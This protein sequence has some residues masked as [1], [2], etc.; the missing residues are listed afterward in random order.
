MPRQEARYDSLVD[1]VLLAQ[2]D[3]SEKM[4]AAL[5]KHNQYID[6]LTNVINQKIK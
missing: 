1:K 5:E 3:C 2:K 6:E 4:N